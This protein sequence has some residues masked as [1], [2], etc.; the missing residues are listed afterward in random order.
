MSRSEELPVERYRRQDQNS[1][2]LFSAAKDRRTFKTIGPIKSDSNGQWQDCEP[3]SLDESNLISSFAVG[4]NFEEHMPVLDI[5]FSAELISSSTPGHFHLYLNKLIPWDKYQALLW[6]LQQAGLIED[7]YYHAALARGAT[8][9]RKPGVT[10]Q[11]EQQ[12]EQQ[13]RF[14]QPAEVPDLELESDT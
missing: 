6:A 11:N 13:A 9:V 8:F 1:R 4:T 14:P 12:Q 7:G 3:A 5:D 10:K 2:P